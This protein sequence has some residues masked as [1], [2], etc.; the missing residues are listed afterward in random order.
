LEQLIATL[1]VARTVKIS[2][3]FRLTG[4]QLCGFFNLLTGNTGL[5]QF[6]L[7]LSMTLSVD[8]NWDILLM[9]DLSN[10]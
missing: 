8:P 7:E 2:I 10:S 1:F 6:L 3:Q 9:V 5:T 4:I